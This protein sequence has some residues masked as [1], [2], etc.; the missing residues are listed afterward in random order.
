MDRKD[1]EKDHTPAEHLKHSPETGKDRR[2]TSG[3]PIETVYFPTDVDADDTPSLGFPGEYPFARGIYP[4]MYRGRLW[5]FRQYAGFGT[6]EETN[7]RFKYLLSRGQTGLSVA[8]DLPTQ[9]GYDS[10]DPLSEGEVGKAGVAIDSV[11]DMDRLFADI[12]LDSVSTSMTINSTA[13]V[14][15]GM[16][17]VVAEA[18][19]IDRKTLTGTVQN[20]VLKEYIARGTYIYPPEPSLKL[21]TD[22][23]SFCGRH[24]PRWN[25]ISVSGYHIREAGSTAVQEIAFTLANAMTY[26]EHAIEA[27]LDVDDFAPR[28]S[29]FFNAHNNILEEIAK[30]RAARRLWARIV[31]E[32]FGAKKKKSWMLR[33]HT[34]TGGSTLT[35]QQPLNNVVRVTLQALA[36]VL[37]GTQSLH[38]NSFDEALSLPTE[39]AVRVALR[40]QQIIAHESGVTDTVDPLGGAYFI[41][42]LTDEI[43]RR[44]SEYIERI[45]SM[46]GVIKAIETGFMKREIETSA[47]DYQRSIEAGQRVVVGVNSFTGE[48]EQLPTLKVDP[49]TEEEQKSRLSALKKSR[50]TTDVSKCLG[51]IESA[52]RSGDNLLELIIEA[53]RKRVTLQEMCDVL[54]RVYGTFEEA[55]RI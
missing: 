45:E 37:G 18:R 55:G 31:R 39:Q 44:A 30:Y 53:A 19:G 8:F 2:T 15:L 51:A 4:D 48:D 12:P 49:A 1:A 41:E 26:V 46:G 34:Q 11:E 36:A 28:M 33:F 17:V 5:T 25:T 21:T 27:G 20:D 43:E 32:R 52:A 23:F 22:I 14:I 42:R 6:C 16:F 13:P 35:A 29:F 10:D 54:R 50:S 24:M 3:I 38:T 9:M 7:E 40:T 47:Y